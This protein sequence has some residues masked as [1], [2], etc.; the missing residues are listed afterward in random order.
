MPDGAKSVSRAAPPFH[1][2]EPEGLNI[3]FISVAGFL[4]SCGYRQLFR[5]PEA[6]RPRGIFFFHSVLALIGP[7][8]PISASGEG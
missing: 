4:N 6:T 5:G 7:H 1:R 3:V 8:D 2:S